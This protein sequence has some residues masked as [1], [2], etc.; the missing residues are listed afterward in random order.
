[1]KNKTA[2]QINSPGRRAAA[3]WFVDGLSEIAFGLV[4]LI[5]GVFA[6][7]TG[8]LDRLNWWMFCGVIVG[9]VLL[10]GMYIKHRRILDYLKARIT[11]PRTG[12]ARPPTCPAR[13]TCPPIY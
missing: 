10:F 1:M 5:Y 13:A 2:E 8:G 9:L 7:V 11:Y 3:Y 12:Y 4:M 6:T